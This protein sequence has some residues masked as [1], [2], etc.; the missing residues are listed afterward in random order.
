MNKTGPGA[1]VSCFDPTFRYRDGE[2]TA[3]PDANP[4]PE[5]SC[6]PGI[7]VS[8]PFYW[9]K[10]DTLIAVSVA[11]EDV[12]ACQA[13]KLRCRAITVIEEVG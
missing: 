1:Y 11:V 9:D 2:T 5:I 3:V 4:D 13:G 6:G 10:G 7:H 12:I 8:T